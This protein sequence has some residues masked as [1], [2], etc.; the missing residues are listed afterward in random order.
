LYYLGVL[1]ARQSV[2]GSS[3]TTSG[4]I[5]LPALLLR[6]GTRSQAQSDS[7]M[8]QQ[9]HR[10]CLVLVLRIGRAAVVYEHPKLATIKLLL[11]AMTLQNSPS[12][13]R[14]IQGISPN[15]H[16]LL[17]GSREG[18]A[19]HTNPKLAVSNPQAN[20]PENACPTLHLQL[21]ILSSGRTAE[22]SG[23]FHATLGQLAGPSFPLFQALL[24]LMRQVE[25]RGVDMPTHVVVGEVSALV[26]HRPIRCTNRTEIAGVERR[27]P[28]R[29]PQGSIVPFHAELAPLARGTH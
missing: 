6:L 25:Q 17:M 4:R 29:G 27:L 13:L 28:A 2:S 21:L 11:E 14:V 18:M 5:M 8:E 1:A 19:D 3:R 26:E 9:G 15:G 12:N 16:I 24:V 10:G 7:M 23:G 20:A 22:N